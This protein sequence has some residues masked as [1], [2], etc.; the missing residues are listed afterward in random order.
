MHQ[1]ENE[2]CAVVN[3]REASD[4]GFR[5]CSDLSHRALEHHRQEAGK[6][7][8]QL[9]RR[10]EKAKSHDSQVCMDCSLD[11]MLSHMILY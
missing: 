4:A 1:S 10:L 6:A 2:I 8:F 3:C 9:K 7:M 5:T 11:W